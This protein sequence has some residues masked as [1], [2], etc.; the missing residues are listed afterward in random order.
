MWQNVSS[1]ADCNDIVNKVQAIKAKVQEDVL[2]TT[3]RFGNFE[4][5]A[6][7]IN[8]TRSS[9][10]WAGARDWANKSSQIVFLVWS[11]VLCAKTLGHNL[12]RQVRDEAQEQLKS[13]GMSSTALKGVLSDSLTLSASV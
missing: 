10:F 12:S 5:K 7:P 11:G 6:S 8:L 1:T 9:Q 13:S 2:L 4:L 3:L